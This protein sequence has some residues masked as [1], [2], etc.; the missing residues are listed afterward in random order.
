MVPNPDH[1]CSLNIEAIIKHYKV[2]WVL[3]DNGSALNLCT[4]KFVTQVGYTIVDIH[5]QCITI[6]AYDNAVRSSIGMI[7]LPI[8]V[9]LVTQSTLCHVVDLDLPLNILLSHT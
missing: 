7:D 5:N 3:I 2:K 8:Q 9:G 6:K 1:I 4:L